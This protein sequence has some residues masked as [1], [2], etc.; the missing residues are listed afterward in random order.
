MSQIIP[1]HN[2]NHSCSSD[3][4]PENEPNRSSS[5]TSNDCSNHSLLSQDHQIVN[6]SKPEIIF[7]LIPQNIEQ[8]P[9]IHEQNLKNNVLI[10]E[11]TTYQQITTTSDIH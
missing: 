9:N 1:Q 7:H 8:Q 10:H 4:P 6:Y 11:N 5:F 2:T 3:S